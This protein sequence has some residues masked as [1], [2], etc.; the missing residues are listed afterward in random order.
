MV[1]TKFIALTRQEL[2]ELILEMCDPDIVGE[3][4]TITCYGL[5]KG[6]EAMFAVKLRKDAYYRAD[7]LD[8]SYYDAEIELEWV[9]ITK[10][11]YHDIIRTE[12]ASLSIDEL[13][14][15]YRRD[16]YTRNLIRERDHYKEM[17]DMATALA[18]AATSLLT[19]Q[20]EK[21]AD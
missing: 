21:E 11:Q 2:T 15:E 13:R 12:C 17:S 14:T 5:E 16:F 3:E 20:Q 9:E 1:V 8:W 7:N 4:S 10:E 18:D 6:E 19:K